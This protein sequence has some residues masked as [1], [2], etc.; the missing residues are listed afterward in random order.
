MEEAT[1][2]SCAVGVLGFFEKEFEFRP[3]YD[4]GGVMLTISRRAEAPH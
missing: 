2:T 1:V 3:G 4:A